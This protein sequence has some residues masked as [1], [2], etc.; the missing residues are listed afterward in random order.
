[1]KKGQFLAPSDMRHVL[2]KLAEGGARRA[3]LTE[4]GT[5]FGYQRLVNDFIGLGDL[6]ELGA[7]HPALPGTPVCF[8]VTHS[9]QLPG[10]DGNA[11]GRRSP[12]ASTRSSS[13]ATP[14][15]GNRSR[16][17]RPCS[18]SRRCPTCSRFSSGSAARPVSPEAGFDPFWPESTD[19]SEETGF[20]G[21][22]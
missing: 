1:V 5:F 16:T 17:P 22:S 20:R 13:S 10:A 2:A 19:S 7:R 12:V 11:P 3:M 15:R 18:R 6:I 21:Y 9:T 4:R 14:D 8:D